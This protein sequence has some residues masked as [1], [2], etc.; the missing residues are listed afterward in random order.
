MFIREIESNFMRLKE[1]IFHV[2]IQMGCVAAMLMLIALPSGAQQIQKKLIETGF[3]SPSPKLLLQNLK[4]IEKMP[5]DGVMIEAA[6]TDDKG[7]AVAIRSTFS[8]KPWKESWFKQTIADLQAVHSRKLTDNLLKIGANPGVDWFDDAGWKQV[9]DHWRIAAKIAKAGNLKGLRFDAEPYGTFRQMGYAAQPGKDKHSFAEYQAKARQRGKEVMAAVAK[10]DPNLLIFC[11]FMNSVNAAA[12]K[13]SNMQT[14]LEKSGYGLYPA[15][16]NGWLDAAPPSMIFVDGC[17]GQGYHAN[18]ELD[19]LKTANVVRNSALAL[20]A[21]EN[22]QKYLS[23]VQVSFGIYLDAYTNPST[24]RYYI[25]PKGE[26]PAHRLIENVAYALN[27]ASEYVWIYGEKY[28]WWATPSKNVNPESWEDKLPGINDGLLGLTHPDWLLQQ[29]YA[30]LD[31]R[32][33]TKQWHFL[34]D[35]AKGQDVTLAA[36][37]DSTWKIIDGG[38]YW[39]RAGFPDYHGPAWYRKTVTVP[40]FSAGQKAILLFDGVDGTCEVF[41]NGKKVGEHVV[42]KDFTGWNTPFQIDASSAFRPGKNVIAVQV[43]SK[44][45]DTASGINQ[46][47]HLLIGTPR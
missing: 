45:T 28:R 1:N 6:G 24:S 38:I 25:D 30:G 44:S 17:E 7:H 4:E 43:T 36:F 11:Y 40:S 39:Q 23:Q 46:P 19:F 32:D 20:V 37:D 47:V 9:V 21:P 2:T 12:V 3:D 35:G 34:P 31:V 33:I 10:V 42:A 22:R 29:K 5:F 41:V 15:F 14:S 26:T 16:I 27:A 18:S 8:P 13:S